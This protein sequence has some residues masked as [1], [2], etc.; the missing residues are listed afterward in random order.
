MLH[1]F[2]EKIEVNHNYFRKEII[3]TMAELVTLVESL[4]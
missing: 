4:T 2:K 3:N 1:D